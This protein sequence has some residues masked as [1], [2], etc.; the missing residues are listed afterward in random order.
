[1]FVASGVFRLN[2]PIR[3]DRGR[4]SHVLRWLNRGGP[5]ETEGWTEVRLVLSR[6]GSRSLPER[7]RG[8]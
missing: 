6:S 4:L 2:A 5:A 7:S 1:L 3:I 8:R